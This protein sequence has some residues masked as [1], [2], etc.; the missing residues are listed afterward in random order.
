MTESLQNKCCCVSKKYSCPSRANDISITQYT[1]SLSTRHRTPQRAPQSARW[2]RCR[3][4]RPCT[5]SGPRIWKPAAGRPHKGTRTIIVA[6]T[7]TAC[8]TISFRKRVC[9]K[10]TRVH[11]RTGAGVTHALLKSRLPELPGVG[12]LSGC[13]NVLRTNRRLEVPL[14]FVK[15][16]EVC[17]AASRQRSTG[18][19]PGLKSPSLSHE[20]MTRVAVVTMACVWWCVVRE[21]GGGG[22]SSSGRNC[23]RLGCDCSGSGRTECLQ[24][25]MPCAQSLSSAHRPGRARGCAQP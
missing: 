14:T 20:R 19:D 10:R 1:R 7:H 23:G 24:A 16:L 12:L 22:T 8:P 3:R 9:K 13:T 17:C 21:G 11:W 15:Y 18:K 6:H 25:C 5:P 4:P 2:S